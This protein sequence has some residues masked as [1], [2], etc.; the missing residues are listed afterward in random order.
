LV[1]WRVFSHCD[2]D[3]QI[4]RYIGHRVPDLRS[5]LLSTVQLLA[6]PQ[7]GTS[8]ALIQELCRRTAAAR[9]KCTGS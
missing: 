1:L 6:E 3:E 2:S 8:Q 5:D 4:A 9:W 7:S